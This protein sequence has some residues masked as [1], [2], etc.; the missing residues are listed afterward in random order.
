MNP[1]ILSH[2]DSIGGA[3]R[4]AYRIHSELILNNIES[5]MMVRVKMLDDDT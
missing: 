5:K 4:A 1:L 2:S 3:A